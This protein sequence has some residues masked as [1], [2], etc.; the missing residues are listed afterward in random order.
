MLTRVIAIS[1]SL[2]LVL[3][4]FAHA[5]DKNYADRLMSDIKKTTSIKEFADNGDSAIVDNDNDATDIE[6]NLG[7]PLKTFVDFLEKYHMLNND[8]LRGVFYKNANRMPFEKVVAELS[9]CM[10]SEFDMIIVANTAASGQGINS[11]PAAQRIKYVRRAVPGSGVPL[12][13]RRNDGM[14]LDFN[15]SGVESGAVVTQE[16]LIPMVQSK[17]GDAANDIL[18]KSFDKQGNILTSSGRG[19]NNGILTFSGLFR[20]NPNKPEFGKGMIHN[21]YVK[22][23]YANDNGEVVRDTGLAIHGT[24]VIQNLGKRDSHGC[25][26][27]HPK[28]ANVW[29]DFVYKSKTFKHDQVLN[30]NTVSALPTDDVK[31]C[32]SGR[33]P[34]YRV[35][36]MIFDGYQN[37]QM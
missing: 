8:K 12:F 4:S 9:E 20:L 6:D 5:V 15:R 28:L 32:Q 2:S 26:R 36:L 16:E 21:M 13:Q 14:I 27:I 33:S 18:A 35:L 25:L 31:S 1:T 29:R 37:I 22:Y 19:G 30:M 17:F 34:G 23:Q 11:L 24:P 10:E 7:A 3:G